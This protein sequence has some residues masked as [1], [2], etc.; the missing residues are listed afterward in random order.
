MKEGFSMEK[1]N[2]TLS[3]PK[4]ILRKGEMLAAKKGISLNELARELPQMTAESEEG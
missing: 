3:L 1:Q 4:E 2:I